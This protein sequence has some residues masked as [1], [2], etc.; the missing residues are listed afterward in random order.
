VSVESPTG[1]VEGAR[2]AAPDGGWTG[3][4]ASPPPPS[5]P[6][7]PFAAY[8]SSRGH[9]CSCS[10]SSSTASEVRHC[11]RRRR[12]PRRRRSSLPL[13]RRRSPRHTSLAHRR[14]RLPSGTP[15]P[16]RHRV[17]LSLSW[18]SHVFA[19]KIYTPLSMCGN[20]RN[21]RKTKKG[22][23]AHIVF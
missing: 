8:L 7:R 13:C 2:R 17:I 22:C 3:V 12:R 14:R 9:S 15:P 6:Y 21:A 1:R 4:S 11:R 23:D 19:L 5:S 10:C 18:V 16:S 20:H